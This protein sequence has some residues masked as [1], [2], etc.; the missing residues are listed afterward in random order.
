MFFCD[1]KR[2]QHAVLRSTLKHHEVVGG[3]F[4]TFSVLRSIE[5]RCFLD[6]AAQR[7]AILIEEHLPLEDWPVCVVAKGRNLTTS[8]PVARERA[9]YEKG[10]VITVGTDEFTYGPLKG[11]RSTHDCHG[12]NTG[13]VVCKA[14]FGPELFRHCILRSFSFCTHRN[15]SKL[16]PPF[17]IELFTPCMKKR[18]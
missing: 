12:R 7:L 11:Y 16:V 15:T 17:G 5:P 9:L 3:T 6:L 18:G 1:R 14:K 13:T 10:S 2:S 4:R 8:V